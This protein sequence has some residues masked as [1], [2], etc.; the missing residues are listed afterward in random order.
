M[1]RIKKT[2][3]RRSVESK[4]IADDNNLAKSV[5]VSEASVSSGDCGVH[6]RDSE[7]ASDCKELVSHDRSAQP[8]P[9]GID[10]YM[11]NGRAA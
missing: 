6:C 8:A 4:V 10:T 7:I 1:Q 3:C 2:V 11:T 5:S 9:T